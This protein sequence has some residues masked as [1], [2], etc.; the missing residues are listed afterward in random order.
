MDEQAIRDLFPITKVEIPTKHGK[1]PLIYF[2]HGA[3][4]QAPKPVLDKYMQVQQ[5]YYSNVHR[6]KHTLSC[7]STKEL[8][9]VADKV[10]RFLGIDDL[11]NSGMYNVLS[12]NTTSA[13]DLGAHVMA[14]EKGDVL[15]TIIEHHS[16]DLPF[17][18]RGKV[19][20]V[21][22]HEDGTLDMDQLEDKLQQ[23][24]IK[25]VAITAASNVTG[26]RPPVEK[27]ARLA[28]DN[29]A[30][31]L[32]DAAQ[33]L[34]HHHIKIQPIDHPEH[35]D[36][37]AAA[38]HKFYSPFGSAFTMG[39]ADLFDAADPYIPG[40]GT[41]RMVNTDDVMY[42]KGPDRHSYGTP[43]I[44]GAIA[45]GASL[46]FLY[47]IGIKEIEKHEQRLLKK[48]ETGLRAI[49]GVEM[50]GDVPFNQKIGVM[51]FN[52]D[53]IYHEDVSRELNREAGIATRNGC[54]CAHPYL[55]RL[56][57]VS[58]ERYTELKRE[59]EAGGDPQMPGAVRAVIGIYNN[60]QDVDELLRVVEDIASKTK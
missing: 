10:A 43:N 29:G 14:R 3:S 21:G 42:L 32:I 38:G 55:L 31:I 20:H 11:E 7:V 9:A 19:H 28:H 36:F 57:K 51:S 24:D 58:P 27:I 34:A 60:E 35:F 33:R 45:M 54:F 12:Y 8:D 23:H 40:G 47:D 4:T 2:D 16:N 41:V 52:I 49:E 39:N 22:I 53:G 17:R 44:A 50:L 15:T 56:L 5:E 46:D 30:K 48:A 6:A 59:I 1:R 13:I 25:L 37:L 26:Y 18:S